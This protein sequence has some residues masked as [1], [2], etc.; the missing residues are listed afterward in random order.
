MKAFERTVITGKTFDEAVRA[1]EEKAAG[2]GFRVLRVYPATAPTLGEKGV[3]R[4]P[5][6]IIEM[7]DAEDTSQV[8][9][10][11]V[12][13]SPVPLCRITV[14]IEN[15]KTHISILLPR[16]VVPFHPEAGIAS[17]ASKLEKTVLEIVEAEL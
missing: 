1:I 17:L 2:K 9:A 15:G 8:L 6:K 3:P 14:Y 11:D 7:Y 16:S 10:K 5:L 4:D 12:E 13:I